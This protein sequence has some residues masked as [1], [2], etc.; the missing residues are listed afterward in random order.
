MI[1]GCHNL[2][3]FDSIIQFVFIDVVN[4]LICSQRATK[5]AFHNIAM[6]KRKIIIY[7]YQ[8]IAA[9]VDLC[10]I[11]AGNTSAS[12]RAVIAF[13]ID[14]ICPFLKRASAMIAS[15][16]CS[17]LPKSVCA[18]WR[19][20]IVLF[21]ELARHTFKGFT[22]ISAFNI[23]ACFARLPKT[24]GGTKDFFRFDIT[25]LSLHGLA[26]M[27]TTKKYRHNFLQ[28]KT[29]FVGQTDVLAE[30]T[31]TAN[32]RRTKKHI[33]FSVFRQYSSLSTGNYITNDV[34][35]QLVGAWVAYKLA[36]SRKL[37]RMNVW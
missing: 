11:T 23:Y 16:N 6:L 25:R 19:T 31:L 33:R 8:P 4:N 18:Q 3:V 17:I 1:I 37:Y 34:F 20:K 15:N 13:F 29:P 32:K 7:P 28:K 5:M 12:L 2:K 36:Q 30:G 9:T 24:L 27:I 21:F 22:A 10:V 14:S 35:L 26:A